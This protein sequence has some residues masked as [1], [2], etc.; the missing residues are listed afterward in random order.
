MVCSTA[1]SLAKMMIGM[2]FIGDATFVIRVFASCIIY[3][4]DHTS[5]TTDI[6]FCAR[7]E[8]NNIGE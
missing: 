8:H 5:S 1:N 4:I 6:A 3:N 7:V 2:G